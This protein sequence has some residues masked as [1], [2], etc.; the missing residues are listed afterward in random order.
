MTVWVP[1]LTIVANRIRAHCPDF[2]EV[3]GATDYVTAVAASMATPA[4]FVV[5]LGEIPGDS[6]L[7]VG[8]AQRVTLHIGVVIAVQNMSDRAGAAALDDLAPARTAVRQALLAWTSAGFTDP[9][10][11]AGGR[12]LEMDNGVLWWQDDFAATYHVRQLEVTSDD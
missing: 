12:L 4:A 2:I 6:D 11:M 8:I 9:W 1:D 10:R 5:P 7:D 3:G